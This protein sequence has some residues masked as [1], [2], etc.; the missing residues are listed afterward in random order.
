M[1]PLVSTLRHWMVQPP[2]QACCHQGF[3]QGRGSPWLRFNK[4]CSEALPAPGGRALPGATLLPLWPPPHCAH[5]PSHPPAHPT[6]PWLSFS[7]LW[8]RGPW[9]V[10]GQHLHL[11][12]Q[13]QRPFSGGPAL[14]EA[15]MPRSLGAHRSAEHNTI[16]ACVLSPRGPVFL[17]PCRLR[18]WPT[19]EIKSSLNSERLG[20]F[21]R[22]LEEKK[23]YHCA[24]LGWAK[25]A[26]AKGDAFLF[27]G[28]SSE[29][30][31]SPPLTFLCHQALSSAAA[32]LHSVLC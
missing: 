8:M 13:L 6:C 17:H 32:L 9:E 5:L 3:Q 2:C 15:W 11:P 1:F 26:G 10:S 28:K 18:D 30:P 16:P 22:R 14:Q 12:W 23:L 29:N 24:R 19:L 21:C 27:P 7:F 31:A 25:G 20:G 4:P